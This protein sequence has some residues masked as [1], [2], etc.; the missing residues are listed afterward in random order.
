MKAIYTAVGLASLQLIATYL[1]VNEVELA[2]M[3]RGVLA[4]SAF[5]WV[6]LILA[7]SLRAMRLTAIV[8]LAVGAVSALINTHISINGSLPSLG[9][10]ALASNGA[11]LEALML[12]PS[13]YIWL[14]LAVTIL[15][16][17]RV[18]PCG[19]F[20]KPS[21]FLGYSLG[22]V[23]TVFLLATSFL[24]VPAF[25][26][27]YAKSFVEF[28]LPTRQIDTG[29][30]QGR[31]D[32]H[33]LVD[34][35]EKGARGALTP[36]KNVILVLVEGLSQAHIDAGWL[37]QLRLLEQRGLKAIRFL[38]HQRQTNRGLYSLFCGA[39]PN[40]LAGVAKADLMALSGLKQSCL[41]HA[42]EKGGVETAFIQ[43]ASLNYMSKDLFAEAAGFSIV[44]GQ[45]EI[46][47]PELV[48]P[49]GVDDVSLYREGLR[50]L[51]SSGPEKRF[52][53]MLTTSTHPPYR[54][55]DGGQGKQE[56]FRYAGEAVGWL[57]DELERRDILDE[58]II[59]ISSDESSTGD[60]AV[61]TELPGDNYGYLLALGGGLSGVATGLRGQV[62]LPAIISEFLGSDWG[63]SGVPLSST[64]HPLRRLYAGNAFQQELYEITADSF[65]RCNT[66]FQCN[67]KVVEQRIYDLVKQNDLTE[68]DQGPI[69]ANMSLRNFDASLD[70]MVL[71]RLITTSPRG[72]TLFA[73]IDLDTSASPDRKEDKVVDF[74]GWDCSEQV[75]GNISLRFTVPGGKST[76]PR[77][78]SFPQKFD[79]QCHKLWVHDLVQ[80]TSSSWKLNEWRLEVD[81]EESAIVDHIAKE[82]FQPSQLKRIAHAGGGLDNKVYTNSIAALDHNYALGFRLFELDFIWTSDS[83]LVCGHDWQDS[84]DKNHGFRY[85]VAPTLA[86]F[87]RDF[88]NSKYAPCTLGA[89][90]DWLVRHPEVEVVTDIKDQN[91]KGLVLLRQS[92]GS[93]A[94][95]IIPQIYAPSEYSVVREIGYE[96]II[97]T[98]Y[99]Y[100]G[101]TRQLLKDISGLQLFAI[102]MPKH[103]ALGG[104]GVLLGKLGIATYTHTINDI[105]SFGVF[106]EHWGIDEIYT[107]FITP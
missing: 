40:L 23:L 77:Y 16:G 10:A 59:I 35:R 96:Q 94:S 39:Y 12:Q 27:W 42:L 85:E 89:L 11:F 67:K 2:A 1:S 99:R 58:T 55:P 49:W 71:G 76:N 60:L 34:S 18:L 17:G 44:K 97:L 88:A 28:N 36:V 22:S 82:K 47:Q 106:R 30:I 103:R 91:L 46:S 4:N 48:G 80:P 57:V 61:H 72:S 5:F 43:A 37:P 95:Q 63:V 33:S 105:N 69:L 45:H 50:Y 101:D 83:Q 38:N 25:S 31:L 100:G 9:H 66:S 52:L 90:T 13:L 78:F 84:V 3:L 104:L 62:D 24:P 70:P 79:Q 32:G 74:L 64:P 81:P 102:T 87:D 15:W 68:A 53:A 93:N 54:V 86:Q 8:L 20:I 98:L 73:K 65:V 6:L 7:S 21:R 41:P 19:L 26:K 51:E 56:A 107:D 29:H 14:V 75:G 92:L